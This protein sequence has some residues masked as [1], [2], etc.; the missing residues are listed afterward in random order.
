[1]FSL[2]RWLRTAKTLATRA[3]AP[4]PT[5]PAGRKG[6][7]VNASNGEPAWKSYASLGFAMLGTFIAGETYLIQQADAARDKEVHIA[8][9]A[10]EYPA[11]ALALLRDACK[12]KTKSRCL[13]DDEMIDFAVWFGKEAEKARDNVP[14]VCDTTRC[15]RPPARKPRTP[16]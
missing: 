15:D 3:N 4:A 11:T 6:A 13:E 12:H 1:M 2:S 8:T 14:E 10:A 5:V 7:N 16:R 9:I